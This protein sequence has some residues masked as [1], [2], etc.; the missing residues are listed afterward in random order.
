MNEIITIA[1]L[2][3]GI[4]LIGNNGGFKGFKVADVI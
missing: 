1:F 4:G 3:V 2:A